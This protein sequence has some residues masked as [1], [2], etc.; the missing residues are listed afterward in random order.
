LGEVDAGNTGNEPYGQENP[1]E[2]Y[3]D[4]NPVLRPLSDTIFLR[5]VFQWA[6]AGDT[7]QSGN[8]SCSA[9]INTGFIPEKEF[10]P[11][12]LRRRCCLVGTRL[13]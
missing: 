10:F 8:F 11:G 13:E 6:E 3:G 2:S 7:G 12:V 4:A 9:R 5:I 1:N